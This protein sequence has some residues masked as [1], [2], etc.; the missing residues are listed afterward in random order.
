MDIDDLNIVMCVLKC[1][2]S[3]G[4]VSVSWGCSFSCGFSYIRRVFLVEHVGRVY[5][6]SRPMVNEWVVLLA[7]QVHFRGKERQQG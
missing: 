4:T 7:K 1:G 2:V 6:S 3:S 5:R